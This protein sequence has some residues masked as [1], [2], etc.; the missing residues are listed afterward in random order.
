MSEGPKRRWDIK[1]TCSILAQVAD[2]EEELSDDE[3]RQ[4]LRALPESVIG[5]GSAGFVTVFAVEA[6]DQAAATRSGLRAWMDA[7][8]RKPLVSQVE[9]APVQRVGSRP[10]D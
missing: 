10:S 3:A 5:F 7:V 1:W 2:G 9:V 8:P 6:E 4:V